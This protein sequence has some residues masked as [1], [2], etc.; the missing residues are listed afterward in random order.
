MF[1]EARNSDM[2]LG[3]LGLELKAR[4]QEL[5]AQQKDGAH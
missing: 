5:E 2:N 1:A 3:E 4:K